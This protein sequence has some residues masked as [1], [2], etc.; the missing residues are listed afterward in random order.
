MK[1][2][3]YI[4]T[5]LLHFSFIRAQQTIPLYPSDIPNSIPSANHESYSKDSGV[6]FKVSQPTLSIFLPEKGKENGT[7]VIICPGG[8]YSVL[9]IKREGF[10]VAR[11]FNKIGV[12]AFVLKYRLPDDEIMKDKSIGP[13][14][15]AQQAI[16]IIRMRAVE[17]KI[18][19]ARIGI[20][21]FSAGGHLASTAATH[22]T[23]SLIVNEESI[24]LRPD[25]QIL[26]YPVISLNNT[27]GHKGTRENLLGKSPSLEKIEY[28]SNELQV[29]DQT[30]TAFIIHGS[31]DHAV[32]VENSIQYYNSMKSKKIPA[33]LHLYSIG[34]HGFPNGLAHD[35]W[36]SYCMDWL[37]A[38]ELVK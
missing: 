37:K 38:L 13:L 5:I 33:S 20:M 19:P 14:Q 3:L 7:A 10:D 2:Y 12:A 11:E 16:K 35:T 28:F 32:P 22:F 34:E 24:N 8:G 6:V 25:F 21:G 36:L 30:P 27:L 17:W 23:K 26:V 29:T 1:I 4:T 31:N 9:V 15:D 18:N